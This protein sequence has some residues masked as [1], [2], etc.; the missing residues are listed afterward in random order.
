MLCFFDMDHYKYARWCS[1]NLFDLSNLEFT[2][3]SLY[4][5]FNIGSFSF[6]KT[7]RN[8]SSRAPD[9]VHEQSNEKI[10]GFGG[11]TH[12]FN[13]PDSTGLEEWGTSAPELVHLLSE[14]EEVITRSFKP[15]TLLPNHEDTPTFQQQFRSDVRSVF[16]N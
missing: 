14:F 16:K 6:Q 10:K 9:Q 8:F 15:Q 4:E 7:K 11:E 2:A 3:P 13:R 12:V 1:V 5:E